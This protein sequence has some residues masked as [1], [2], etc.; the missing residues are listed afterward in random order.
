MLFAME[1]D[2][3]FGNFCE[4]GNRAEA[5]KYAFDY[6]KE[7]DIV[8]ICGKGHENY[9]IIGDQVFD[10]SDQEEILKLINA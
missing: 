1:N 5:I 2:D 4:I 8:V 6:A 3:F 9:Q 10:F 7:G